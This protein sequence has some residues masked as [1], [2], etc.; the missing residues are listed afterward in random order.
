ME[1]HGIGTTFDACTAE[2]IGRAMQYCIDHEA[3][4]SQWKR[5]ARMI[6]EAE[7]NYETQSDKFNSMITRYL[8]G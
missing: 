8:T 2:A 3:L 7:Y 6:A 4:I 5:K 1:E